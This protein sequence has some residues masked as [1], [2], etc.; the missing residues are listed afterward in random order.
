MDGHGEIS[1]VQGESRG[2]DRLGFQASTCSLKLSVRAN[3]YLV[4]RL[5]PSKI[6]L[7]TCV[8]LKRKTKTT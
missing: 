4:S 3:R 2:E 1:L 8:T 7:S 5:P 6:L